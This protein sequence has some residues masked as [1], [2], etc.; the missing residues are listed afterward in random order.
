[1]KAVIESVKPVRKRFAGTTFVHP[2]SPSVAKAPPLSGGKLY[3]GFE[4]VE[5]VKNPLEHSFFILGQ[6]VPVEAI[7][8]HARTLPDK[9]MT[10]REAEIKRIVLHDSQRL[11]EESSLNERISA[12]HGCAGASNGIPFK[13]LE[14]IIL[15]WSADMGRTHHI[16]IFIDNPLCPET[17]GG[18]GVLAKSLDMS[19]K[20]S[21]GQQVVG[22]EKQQ[23]IPGTLREAEIPGCRAAVIIRSEDCNISTLQ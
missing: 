9:R 2:A 10:T 18:C 1:V 3:F 5:G 11:V 14:E 13:K 16:A 17:K 23:I 15:A 7:V 20:G 8:D 4:P 22:I 6:A 12:D 21:R 19:F